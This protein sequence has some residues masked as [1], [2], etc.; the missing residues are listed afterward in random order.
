MELVGS[1]AKN[2]EMQWILP[3]RLFSNPSRWCC[4]RP[5]VESLEINR[6]LVTH[7]V[8]TECLESK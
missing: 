2:E 8:A 4:D 3:M 6:S 7:S 5:T 1:L